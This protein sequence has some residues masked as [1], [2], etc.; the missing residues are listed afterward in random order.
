MLRN[1]SQSML[2]VKCWS[3]SGVRQ[4]TGLLPRHAATLTYGDI[5]QVP[6]QPADIFKTLEKTVSIAGFREWG[7][8]VVC[9]AAPAHVSLHDAQLK[10]K[11]FMLLVD[12]MEQQV[13]VNSQIS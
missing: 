10:L 7:L 1:A 8:E 6:V 9:T 3:A 11:P 13:S 4:G 5:Y 2:L 12:S